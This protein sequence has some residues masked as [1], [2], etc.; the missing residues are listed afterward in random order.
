MRHVL[1][2]NGVYTCVDAASHDYKE[3]QTRYLNLIANK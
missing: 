2:K 3:R 1:S